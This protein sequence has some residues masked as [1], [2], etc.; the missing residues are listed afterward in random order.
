MQCIPMVMRSEVKV[1]AKGWQENT[2]P[3]M[4]LVGFE[5]GTAGPQ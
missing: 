3:V 4:Q 2:L 1:L 5:P